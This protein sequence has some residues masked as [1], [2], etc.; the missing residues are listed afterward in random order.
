MSV[1][2]KGLSPKQQRFVAEYLVDLNG[3]QAAIRAGYS[4]RTA[5]TQAAQL[6][7]KRNISEAVEKAQHRQLERA[8]TETGRCV[9]RDAILVKNWFE[10]LHAPRAGAVDFR[11]S[12]DRL[13]S[14]RSL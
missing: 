6:L 13:T 7:A 10:E 5:R 2:E 3:T 8:G 4:K 14:T 11:L 1:A 12:S 9:R